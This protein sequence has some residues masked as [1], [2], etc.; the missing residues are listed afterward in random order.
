VQNLKRHADDSVDAGREFV[1][2]Y[3]EF[4]HY[5]ERLHL[6]ATSPAS[7]TPAGMEHGH[8]THE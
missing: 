5:A 8:G 4:V 3:V 2:A 1:A 6:D 7:H